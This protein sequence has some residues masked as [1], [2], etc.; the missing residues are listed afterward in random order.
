M[1][2]GCGSGAAP[3][4]CADTAALCALKRHAVF[5][6]WCTKAE[7]VGGASIP[8]SGDT[9]RRAASDIC[10]Q[11]GQLAPSRVFFTC[12]SV[13]RDRRCLNAC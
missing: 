7:S 9:C 4:R 5:V 2:A 10:V 13:R 11:R 1:S 8:L 6:S 12:C 3:G